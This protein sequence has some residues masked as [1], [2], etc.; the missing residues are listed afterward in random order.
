MTTPETVTIIIII[1]GV[2]PA[3][4]LWWWMADGL[5][6]NVQSG[7]NDDNAAVRAFIFV[8]DA[9]ADTLIVHDDGNKMHQTVYDDG[10]AISALRR[11]LRMQKKLRVRFLFNEQADLEMVNVL[12]SEFPTRIDVRYMRGGRPRGDVHYKIADAGIVGHLSKQEYGQPERHF[13]LFD[14]SANNQ[15]SRKRVFGKYLERFEQDFEAAQA[16]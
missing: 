8:V 10:D 12:R 13:K 6:M 4:S 15:R 14:C 2:A 1:L 3:I 9:A 5:R 11:Q 16:S 7:F